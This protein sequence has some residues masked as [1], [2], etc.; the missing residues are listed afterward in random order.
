M[1]NICFFIDDITKTGGTERVTTQIANLLSECH[2]IS[3]L[4]IHESQENVF[5]PLSDEISHTQLFSQKIHGALHFLEI[6]SKLRRYV[7]NN[8]IDI[9]VDVDGFLD[10]YS[11]PV[12]AFTGVKIVSWEHFNYFQNFGTPYRKVSRRLA[13]K[14]ADGVVTLTQ[15]DNNLYH[16]YLNV[17][18]PIVTIHNPMPQ[19]T[20]SQ[21]YNSDSKIILSA[22]RLT[23]QK[24]FDL[25]PVIAKAVF[26][27][28]PDWKWYVLGVGEKKREIQDTINSLNLS[29]HVILQGKV[30]DMNSWYS[31]SA[32]Y[33]MTSRFEGLPM[34]LLEAKAHRLPII[35]FDCLTG[36]SEIIRNN[37]NGFLIKP[38][39]ITSMAQAINT[40]IED[41]EKRLDMSRQTIL[42]SESFSVNQIKQQWITLLRN[43]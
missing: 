7:K 6:V 27:Q 28:H 8:R 43:I 1:S 35:S 2:Q 38:E 23:D 15:T 26:E 4:S 12:K 10:L 3:I 11:L 33:V 40:L 17:R 39:D 30:S 18:C 31:K 36:P 32:F 19:I 5:F 16:K 22:G 29:S 37:I 14:F 25:I 21:L 24:G 20:E 13:S 34:V 41:E 9:I 42:D